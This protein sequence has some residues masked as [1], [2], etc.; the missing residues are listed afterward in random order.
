MNKPATTTPS[1]SPQTSPRNPEEIRKA[2]TTF[3][4]T[5]GLRVTG[6]RLAIFKVVEARTTHFTAEDLFDEVRRVDS[7]VSRATIYRSLPILIGNGLIR[8]V[9]IGREQKY[10]VNTLRQNTFQAQL[11]CQDCDKIIEVDAPFMDWYGKTLA[12]KHNMELASQRL[13]V[14]AH[15]R[16]C[17]EKTN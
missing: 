5:R 7:S 10:Y 1:Q 9:D 13:Q 15:C 2:F 12:A 6:Q 11:V 3:L 8:E 4:A 16:D 14:L 17:I